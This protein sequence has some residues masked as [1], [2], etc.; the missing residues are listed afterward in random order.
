MAAVCLLTCNLPLFGK[1]TEKKISPPNTA[2]ISKKDGRVQA[3]PYL[4]KVY[5]PA[6]VDEL[7][8]PAISPKLS[9]ALQYQK[10]L[11]EMRSP[12]NYFKVGNLSV[13]KQQMKKT[14]AAL[15]YWNSAAIVP[16]SEYFDVY[17][18]NGVDSKGSVK[19]TGYYS[20][21]V[22]V[23][24]QPDGVY[25]HP[26][27]AAPSG[28]GAPMPTRK[29]I[30]AGALKGQGLEIA[31]AKSMMEIY[32]LQMQG[33]GYVQY[34]NGK[35]ELLSYAGTN[36]HSRRSLQLH[37]KENY[38]D[39]AP[40]NASLGNFLKSNPDKTE[41]VI[42]SDPSYVF[43]KTKPGMSAT[44]GAGHVPLT[45]DHSIAVDPRFVPLGACLLANVPNSNKRGQFLHHS[46]R[47][48]LAQDTGGAIKGKGHV[49]LYTGTGLVAKKK[50]ALHHYGQMW[51]LLAKPL[52]EVGV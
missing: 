39:I 21:I 30:E 52:V 23:R 43:F 15:E 42:T 41:E 24:K 12:G 26:I 45:E 28:S 36:G 46:L 47:L 50:A 10:N 40:I 19:F 49:D 13:S 34:P 6:N 32:Q 11:L 35:T 4:K 5:T 33:S 18:I 20:P 17:Q 44:K 38:Q 16:F 48:L 1:T 25:R 51:L 22:S 2:N 8:V 14:I 37:I 31:Y 27:Y 29:Q 3:K 9:K 7:K